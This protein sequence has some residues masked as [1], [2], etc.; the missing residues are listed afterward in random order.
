MRARL[1]RMSP[2]EEF[3]FLCVEKMADGMDKV[4]SAGGGKIVARV[5][6]SYA[7]VLSVRKGH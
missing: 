6:R 7:V 3:H 2:G 5:D 4:V 1:E